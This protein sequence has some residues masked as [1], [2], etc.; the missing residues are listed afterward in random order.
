[1]SR[2][3]AAVLL[4]LGLVLQACGNCDENCRECRDANDAALELCEAACVNDG[5]LCLDACATSHCVAD[6][7]CDGEPLEQECVF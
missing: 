4:C 5:N 7:A 6:D 2:T 3:T 1:M